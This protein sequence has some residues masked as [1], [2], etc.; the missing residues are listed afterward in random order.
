M[1]RAVK[2]SEPRTPQRP[3]GPFEWNAQPPGA[4]PWLAPAAWT[5]LALYAAATLAIIAGPHRVGDVFT[6]TD[7]Y[8][9]YGL[10][11]R[12]IQHGHVD[13]SRYAVVGPVYEFALACFGLLV[14]DLFLAAELLSAIAMTATLWAWHRLLRARGNA[15]LALLALLFLAVDGQFL[16]YGYSATTDAL[17]L[18]LEAMALL[19]LL[20]GT[21]SPARVAGAGAVAG[22]AFLTRYSYAAL[23]PAGLLAV[24]L[25][26]IDAPRER[27]LQTALAFAGGFLAPVLPWVAY[28]LTSGAHLSFRLHHNIA[29]DVFAR[30]KGIP[31]DAYQRTMQPSFPTPWSVLARDP[32]A[33][34]A[35]MGFNVLDH[36]RLDAFKVAGFPL[37][38]AALAGTLLAWRDGTLARLRPLL[39]A[40][41]WLFLALVP[42]FHSE[43]YSL[44]LL[45]LWAALGAAAFTSP[46]LALSVNAGSGR[47]IWLKPAL[48]LVP[49]WF[50]LQASVA[51]QNRTFDLLPV[52]VLQIARQAR[53]FLRA[54][55][56]VIA[57]K[58]HF[59]W[60]ADLVAEPFPFADSL[61]QARGRGA[62]A[63]RALALLLVAGSRACA[64]PSRSCSTPAEWCRDSPCAPRPSTTRPCSTRSAPVSGRRRHGCRTTRCFRCTGRA[65]SA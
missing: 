42:A 43:R 1:K 30:A 20:G 55:D 62:R 59:A 40:A 17:A 34:I 29:Y 44:A 38:L 31:W 15:A 19:L 28:S 63:P 64:T 3:G 61:S 10:G 49:G 11:A 50:A 12:G 25:G 13:A 46:L 21:A 47:R 36:F 51:L 53:P 35:R 2:P 60:H 65:R 5:L 24:L 56:R 6:E 32:G 14:R 45:P 52:E 48:A 54:G 18:A 22:L 27:R 41:A 9:A 8:G 16:R 57:R 39:L 33:V 58:P 37:A 7:F 4:A 23:L 26:W